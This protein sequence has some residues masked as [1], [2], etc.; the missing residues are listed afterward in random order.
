ML[1]RFEENMPSIVYI[2]REVGKTGGARYATAEDAVSGAVE[3]FRETGVACE[4]WIEVNRQQP[5]FSAF[6]TEEVRQC[7]SR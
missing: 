3:W 4:I 5:G 2:V 7:V 6:F 1:R